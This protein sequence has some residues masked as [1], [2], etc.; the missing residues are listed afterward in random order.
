MSKSIVIVGAGG[1][2]GLSVAREFGRQGFN[3]GLIARKQN[4]LDKL[5]GDLAEGGVRSVKTAIAD[6]TQPQEL[7]AALDSLRATFGAIDVLEYSPAIGFPNYKATL[8]VS[9]ENALY[10][11]N[12]LVAGAITAVQNVLPEMSARKSGALLFTSGAAAL[13]PIPFLANVGVATAGLRNYLANLSTALSPKGIYVGCIFVGGVM[14]RGT[15]VD[16][17]RI[18]AK[19]FDMYT[20]RD[21]SEETVKGPPPPKGPPPKP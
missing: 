20:K 4:S 10:S 14:K 3:V 2:I 17:D 1:T 8:D 6:V 5:V 13:A 21:R 19:F 15:E 16:P 7:N 9:A 18:A 12:V 11:F